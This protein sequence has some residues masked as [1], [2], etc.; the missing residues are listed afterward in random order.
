MQGIN[1]DQATLVDTGFK[2]DRE[3]MLVDNKNK[4]LSQRELPKM[5]L[6]KTQ[7]KDDYLIL[8]NPMGDSIKV[9]LKASN[10]NEIK[11]KVWSDNVWANEA[12][13][14]INQWLSAEFKR[15]CKLVQLNQ[16]TQR[17]V[18]P[19]FAK[20][21]QLV[22]F[23]DG[24]PLLI[25]SESSIDLLN[26]KLETPVEMNRFRPNIVIEGFKAHQEDSLTH[27]QINGIEFNLAK[28]CSRCSIPSINQ[29]NA[30]RHPTLLRTLTRYRKQGNEILFGMNALHSKLGII[31]AGDTIKI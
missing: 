9:P 23:A 19:N 15:P 28:P 11:V 6:I 30:D 13:A 1:L 21:N 10:Q 17:K 2:H 25:V 26:S 14:S 29:N 31:K 5:A 7:I 16:N 3:W 24:F 18:D 22:G 20:Y 4:F 8:S 27:I 12:D